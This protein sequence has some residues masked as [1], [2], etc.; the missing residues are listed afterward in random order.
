MS[1]LKKS[2]N[3]E[4]WAFER[5]LMWISEFSEINAWKGTGKRTLALGWKQ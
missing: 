4:S 5:S 2:R 3:K 1:N